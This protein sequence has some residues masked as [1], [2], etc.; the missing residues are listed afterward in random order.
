MASATS[1]MSSASRVQ[2]EPGSWGEIIHEVQVGFVV[3]VM[4]SWYFIDKF[5]KDQIA[6]PVKSIFGLPVESSVDT[7]DQ[8]EGKEKTLKV[9]GV[10]YGRTGTVGFWYLMDL[11]VLVAKLPLFVEGDWFIIDSG[12]SLDTH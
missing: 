8:G 10:G 7:L 11:F 6:A 3:G 5:L 4:H 1:G 9:V 2:H 12:C